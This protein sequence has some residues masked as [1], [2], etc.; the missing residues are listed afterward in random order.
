MKTLSIYLL[1]FF[2]HC[3]ERFHKCSSVKKRKEQ[4]KE[5]ETVVHDLLPNLLRILFSVKIP[6]HPPSDIF[7][8]IKTI[9]LFYCLLIKLNK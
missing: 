1:H 9:I 7:R 6:V 3:I 4:K 2:S 5:E 8:L